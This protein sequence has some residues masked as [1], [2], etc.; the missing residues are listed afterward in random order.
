MVQLEVNR[1]SHNRYGSQLFLNGTALVNLSYPITSYE[2]EAGG[3]YCIPMIGV[4][5][6]FKLQYTI[7]SIFIG[8]SGPMCWKGKETRTRVSES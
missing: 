3:W 4:V 5:R 1:S 6:G 7:A 8:S 2:T